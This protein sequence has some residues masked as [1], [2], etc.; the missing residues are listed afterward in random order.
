[1]VVKFGSASEQRLVEL[2]DLFQHKVDCCIPACHFVVG[3]AE[4]CKQF[5]ERLRVA[6]AA[7]QLRFRA[8]IL[9][10]SLCIVYT[11]NFLSHI[12]ACNLHIHTYNHLLTTCCFCPVTAQTPG[13]R[14]AMQERNTEMHRS[15]R[16]GV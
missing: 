3:T 7:R 6:A 11:I 14:V 9:F 13:Q 1:M 5:K 2:L 8:G 4:Q 10:L 12:M 16:T 15:F